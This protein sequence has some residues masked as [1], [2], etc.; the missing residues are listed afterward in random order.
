MLRPS[1]MQGVE[2]NLPQVRALARRSL[3]L[4]SGRE[5]DLASVE[6]ITETGFSGHLGPMRPWTHRP[7]EA[8]VADHT[9]RQSNVLDMEPLL[10]RSPG[11][12]KPVQSTTLL[13]WSDQPE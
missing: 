12:A 8:G 4:E 13:I 7:Q 11:P 3:G 1:R 9:Q 10:P 2:L 6:A 5:A